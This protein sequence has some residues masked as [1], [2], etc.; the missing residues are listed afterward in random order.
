[1]GTPHHV[2]IS[3]EVAVEDYSLVSAEVGART[4]RGVLGR[5]I[6]GTSTIS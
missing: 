3:A 5:G 4:I 1:M 6:L 2:A